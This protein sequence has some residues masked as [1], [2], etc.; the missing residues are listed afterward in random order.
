MAVLHLVVPNFDSHPVIVNDNRWHSSLKFAIKR[1][2]SKLIE[3]HVSNNNISRLMLI[4]TLSNYNW[5]I[6]KFAWHSLK[7]EYR[8]HKYEDMKYETSEISHYFS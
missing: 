4:K 5:D 6:W 2:Q 7:H 8:R 3:K 1:S